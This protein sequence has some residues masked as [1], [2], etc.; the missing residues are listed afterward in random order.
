MDD[1]SLVVE[2]VKMNV[3]VGVTEGARHTKEGTEVQQAAG[4]GRDALKAGGALQFVPSE[5][6]GLAKP[7]QHTPIFLPRYCHNTSSQ[8]KERSARP[9]HDVQAE[10]LRKVRAFPLRPSRG[11]GT[12]VRCSAR[13]TP[14]R[15]PATHIRY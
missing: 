5:L 7:P 13:S 8:R 10:A 9:E 4:R 15:V 11:P 14:D 1:W 3:G 12:S 2:E 6:V